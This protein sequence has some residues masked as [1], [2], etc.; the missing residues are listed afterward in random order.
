MRKVPAMARAQIVDD[1]DPVIA[2]D[3]LLRQM[4]SDEACAAVTR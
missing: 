2:T 4:R 1:T 3:E